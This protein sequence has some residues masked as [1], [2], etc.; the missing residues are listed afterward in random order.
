MPPAP[1]G[2]NV[3]FRSTS[4]GATWSPPIDTD[5]RDGWLGVQ[6]DAALPMFQKEYG[7]IVGLEAP[8]GSVLALVRPAKAPTMWSSR[9]DT[10]GISW[11]PLT[12]GVFPMYALGSAALTTESGVMLVGGRFPSL[13]IQA[14]WDNGHTWNMYVI[15][16]CDTAQGT[17]MEVR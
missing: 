9:S 4:G 13:A 14:S 16:S 5:G 12:R 3:V 8:D 15:D 11:R 10:G 17:M 6:G 2:A 7:E 1:V